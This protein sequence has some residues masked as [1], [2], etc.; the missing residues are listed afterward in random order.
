[1]RSPV[2]LSLTTLV[3]VACAELRWAKPGVDA[4]A[5]QQDL[6]ACRLQ[7][8]AQVARSGPSLPPVT[9]PRFGTETGQ[10]KQVDQPVR[11]EELAHRC[12]RDKGYSLVPGLATEDK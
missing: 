2:L 8:R 12:M 6:D 10:A 7:A 3:L 5:L 4:T 1:M 9:D 11:E